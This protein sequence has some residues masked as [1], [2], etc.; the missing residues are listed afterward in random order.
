M[1]IPGPTEKM[2][3]HVQQKPG[4]SYPKPAEHMF[5]Q[6]QLYHPALNYHQPAGNKYQ[7]LPS[8]GGYGHP[9]AQGH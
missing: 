1:H 6:E 3:I 2:S 7:Y 5:I 8:P 9:G 4:F